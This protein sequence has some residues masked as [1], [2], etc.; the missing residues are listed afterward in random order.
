VQNRALS[1]G[2]TQTHT[3]NNA[4]ISHYRWFPDRIA[5]HI[6]AF[7]GDSKVTFFD[8]T[9]RRRGGREHDAG[10]TA[11]DLLLPRLMSGELAV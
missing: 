3:R 8:G 2:K 1:L 11:G 7:E 10:G 5:T 4:L 9:V 6:L